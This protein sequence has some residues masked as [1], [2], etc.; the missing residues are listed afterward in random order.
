MRSPREIPLVYMP[1]IILMLPARSS[2]HPVGGAKLKFS[3]IVLY[4]LVLL[5]PINADT[6]S[7]KS[8]HLR[9]DLFCLKSE[10]YKNSGLL[11]YNF[12][13]N[14]LPIKPHF[15]KNREIFW[16]TKNHYYIHQITIKKCSEPDLNICICSKVRGMGTLLTPCI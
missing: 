5:A 6:V 14:L 16:S 3:S 15:W 9:W 7:L 11:W 2:Y 1:L 10:S 13:V 8:R 12:W 4:F